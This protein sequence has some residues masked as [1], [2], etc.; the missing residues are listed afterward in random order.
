MDNSGYVCDFLDYVLLK[1]KAVPL[2]SE[3][4]LKGSDSGVEHSG[5]LAFRTLFI[6]EYSEEHN[7]SETDSVSETLC[8]LR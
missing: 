6:V 5:L 7:F 3:E 2:T 1:L 8:S 4:T